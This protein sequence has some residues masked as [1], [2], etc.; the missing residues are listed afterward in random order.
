MPKLKDFNAEENE[1]F[2]F[3]DLRD[4][5]ELE[6]LI[7]AKNKIKRIKAPLPFLP[8]MTHLS[9]AENEI[10][11]FTEILNLSKKQYHTKL[12]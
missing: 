5:P 11:N 6:S 3:R 9:L 1:I 10:V 8:S 7:L 2:D 12:F 4:L